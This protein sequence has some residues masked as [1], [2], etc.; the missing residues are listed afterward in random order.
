[1]TKFLVIF[2]SSLV[3]NGSISQ[4]LPKAL[5]TE[6]QKIEEMDPN[7]PINLNKAQKKRLLLLGQVCGGLGHVLTRNSMF[8]LSSCF[9]DGL[10]SVLSN[11]DFIHFVYSSCSNGNTDFQTPNNAWQRGACISQMIKGSDFFDE[12]MA[13]NGESQM[14]DYYRCALKEFPRILAK[15]K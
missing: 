12:F 6:H 1:M 14:G 15:S 8:V 2:L 11:E 13:C 3:A 7:G 10:N 4:S 5:I 9:I